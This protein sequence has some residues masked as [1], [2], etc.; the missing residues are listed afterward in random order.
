MADRPVGVGSEEKIESWADRNRIGRE[1]KH[2]N[3]ALESQPTSEI[4]AASAA[5][6]RKKTFRCRRGEI[7]DDREALGESRRHHGRRRS[8]I[9]REHKPPSDLKMCARRFRMLVN[10]LIVLCQILLEMAE[11]KGRVAGL[12]L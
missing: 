4:T 5:F 12:N 7:W 10:T 1:G 9:V 6:H 8:T 3:A 11:P 2:G